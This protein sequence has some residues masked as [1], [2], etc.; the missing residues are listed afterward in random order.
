MCDITVI[1]PVYNQEQYVIRCVISILNQT[2]RDFTLVLVDDG[3][4]DSSGSI[5]DELLLEYDNVFVIHEKN[6]GLSFA[7]NMGIDLNKVCICSN[8]ITFIDSDD[9][10]HS[11]YFEFMLN[12]ARKYQVNVVVSDFTRTEY[13]KQLDVDFTK[14]TIC[15]PEEFICNDRTG[16]SVAC[17][18][19][20]DSSSFETIRFPI[21]KYHE[22]EFTTYKVL[23]NYDKLAIIHFPLYN[24][25]VNDDSI[26]QS[27]WTPKRLDAVDALSSQIDFFNA[28][29]Y[30]DALQSSIGCKLWVLKDASEKAQTDYPE[31]AKELNTR[32]IREFKEYKSLLPI[33]EYGQFYKYV[34]PSRFKLYTMSRKMK[35]LIVKR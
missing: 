9:W 21:G 11:R 32:F 8:W 18:K 22:D 3:S 34:Y 33:S 29:H 10:V 35:S 2:Y 1:V 14:I 23:F 17:C 7:R 26:T 31:L 4:S 15:S 19:L 25:F 13:D 24:Y 6:A 30:N 28:N 27:K 20:F 12:T 16:F 5:C